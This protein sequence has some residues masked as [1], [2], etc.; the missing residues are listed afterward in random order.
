MFNCSCCNP[1]KSF[2]YSKSVWRH[3]RK[4]NPEYRTPDQVRRDQYA[5]NPRSCENCNRHLTY[6][7]ICTDKQRR[8]CSRKC[9]AK[10][11][12]PRL[13]EARKQETALCL[14]C[15][16][17]VE[18]R[19]KY[20]SV[21][22]NLSHRRDLI[23]GKIEAGEIAQRPTLKRHLLAQRGWQCEVCLNTEWTGEPIPLELDHIDGNAGNNF[24]SNLRLICPNC[25]AMTP[26]AK[27]KNKGNGR[28]ARGLPR[29]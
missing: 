26:T 23:H 12:I 21:A 14:A 28:A 8:Y 20:C 6:E 3:E 25:H 11:N 18:Y 1:P 22:C 5:T 19:K 9:A 17:E 24:P 15:S 2:K 4:H 7:Q 13:A 10:V 27:G 16:S 29:C